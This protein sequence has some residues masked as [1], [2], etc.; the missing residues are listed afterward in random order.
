MLGRVPDTG[1]YQTV[2]QTENTGERPEGYVCQWDQEPRGGLGITESRVRLGS[3]AMNS[4]RQPVM[5]FSGDPSGLQEEA[6]L[7]R[8]TH[9]CLLGAD[10]SP[11]HGEH[12]EAYCEAR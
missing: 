12:Q 3:Y 11:L 1:R 4:Q 6:G 2:S 5:S 7:W 10:G 8:G 9:P